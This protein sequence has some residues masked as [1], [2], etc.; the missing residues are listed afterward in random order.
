MYFT[1][2]ALIATNDIKFYYSDQLFLNLNIFI[3]P[4]ILIIRKLSVVKCN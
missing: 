2:T 1:I 4:N 3:V